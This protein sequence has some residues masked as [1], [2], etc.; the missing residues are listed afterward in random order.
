MPTLFSPLI[1]G[2]GKVMWA[3]KHS[4][5]DS[6]TSLVTPFSTVSIE[7][8]KFVA[9]IPESTTSHDDTTDTD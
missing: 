7:T 2:E 8:R 9:F 5:L 4:L 1:V 6:A 3:P